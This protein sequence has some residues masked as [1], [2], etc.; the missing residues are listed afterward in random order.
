MAPSSMWPYN[1]INYTVTIVWVQL[2]CI[3][4]YN[5]TD[6][7]YTLYMAYVSIFGMTL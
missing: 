5:P 4:T 6:T 3:W 1:Y 2:S 7:T